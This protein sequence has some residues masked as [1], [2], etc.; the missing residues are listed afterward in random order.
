MNY[1]II[2]FRRTKKINIDLTLKGT[3][4]FNKI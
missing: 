2:T 1:V 3:E 4:R